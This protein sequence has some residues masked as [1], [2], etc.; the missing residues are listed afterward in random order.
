VTDKKTRRHGCR[1][2]W[3]EAVLVQSAYIPIAIM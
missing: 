3:R 1:P 2:I